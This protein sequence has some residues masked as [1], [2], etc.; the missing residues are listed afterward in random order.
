VKFFCQSYDPEE[1]A[2]KRRREEHP[3]VLTQ[4]VG[5]A[6]QEE[7]DRELLR[8]IISTNSSFRLV[9]DPYFRAFSAK[10]SSIYTPPSRS[11][12]SG[13]VLKKEYD[14]CRNALQK[15]VD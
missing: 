10:L 8:F 12:I 14:T 4:M 5:K 7:R 15:I 11:K 1:K 13:S 2:L 9:E 6:S 3:N